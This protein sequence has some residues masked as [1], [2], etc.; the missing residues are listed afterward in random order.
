MPDCIK[1]AVL[2]A[3]VLLAVFAA[4]SPPAHAQTLK[5]VKE[6]GVLRCGV[7]QGLLGFSSQDDQSNWRGLDVDICRAVAAAVLG[8]PAKVTFAPLDAASRFSALQSGQIDLLSRNSTWT[9]SRETSL[10]LMFAGVAYFDGQGFLLRRDSG[11]DTAL[12]LGGKT[13]CAQT[14]TTSQLNVAD[15]FRVNDMALKV[16]A[17]DTVEESRKA[18]DD[19]KCDV[20]TSDV[21]QLYAERLKLAAPDSHVILPE[22]ISKEPL[23]PV[24]RQGDDQW[25]NLVKWTL[26]ALINAEELGIKSSTID[27]ALKSSDPNVRRLVGTEGEFGLQLGLSNDWAVRAVRATGNY[28][29]IYERNVGT[30]SRLSVPRGLNALWTKGG[31]Q[32]AP[33]IR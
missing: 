18:Y 7:G 12:Q 23:G 27:D 26:Y 11:I 21:S 1:R 13:V 14:G 5:A 9:M 6:R 17:L 8:D 25:F 15:Y 2:S 28:G 22:V 3:A 29:E 33:P 16:L 30:Q 10:G 4:G 19:R 20:L 32:Y 24:V 31:I